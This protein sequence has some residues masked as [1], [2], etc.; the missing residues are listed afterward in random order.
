MVPEMMV[1]IAQSIMSL[2]MTS[3]LECFFFILG[4]C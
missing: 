2:V 3:D 1:L 4:L